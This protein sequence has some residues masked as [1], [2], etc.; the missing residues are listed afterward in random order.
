MTQNNINSTFATPFLFPTSFGIICIC[1][2]AHELHKNGEGQCGPCPGRFPCNLSCKKYVPNPKQRAILSVNIP[3]ILCER[4]K[5]HVGLKHGHK[6]GSLSFEVERA[7]REYLGE[8]DL[9]VFMNDK[10]W[11][12]FNK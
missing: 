11:Q 9:D 2:H 1:G 10:E 3:A 12:L 7:L 6:K 4:F 5:N 8:K